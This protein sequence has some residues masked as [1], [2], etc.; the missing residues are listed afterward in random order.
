[1]ENLHQYPWLVHASICAAFIVIFSL[2]QTLPVL[3]INRQQPI[4]NI[5]S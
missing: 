1:M 2:I 4:Q 5:R 3:Q